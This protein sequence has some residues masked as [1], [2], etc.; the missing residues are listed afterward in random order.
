MQ[1]MKKKQNKTGAQ[2]VGQEIIY[3]YLKLAAHIIFENP[4]SQRGSSSLAA[5]LLRISLARIGLVCLRE[6]K[7]VY[8]IQ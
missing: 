3:W 4:T 7:R 5:I 1:I 8:L 2:F 6:K